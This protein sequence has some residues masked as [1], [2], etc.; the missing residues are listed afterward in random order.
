MKTNNTETLPEASN[1][2]QERPGR[3]MRRADMVITEFHQLV[4][5]G[6]FNR[7]RIMEVVAELKGSYARAEESMQC[8]EGP[9]HPLDLDTI[10]LE[11]AL[12]A[13]KDRV[14]ETLKHPRLRSAA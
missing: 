6:F 9:K 10:E 5:N 1:V 12:K 7:E 8:L 4:Q 11:A 13:K 3:P 14:A 2:N